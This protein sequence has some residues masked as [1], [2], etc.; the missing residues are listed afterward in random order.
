[1]YKTGPDL[2]FQYEVLSEY[3]GKSLEI[4]VIYSKVAWNPCL[5]CLVPTTAGRIQ[6]SCLQPCKRS[7]YTVHAACAQPHSIRQLHF[8]DHLVF[9][10]IKFYLPVIFFLLFNIWFL[11]STEMNSFPCGFGVFCL[12]LPP[13]DNNSLFPELNSWYFQSY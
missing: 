1:M 5:A 11:E 6:I 12:L 3:L 4:E 7:P 2:S 8:F 9:H 13:T 10:R